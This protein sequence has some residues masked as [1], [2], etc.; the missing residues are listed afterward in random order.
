VLRFAGYELD[1]QRAELRSPNGEAIKL[2]PKS[3]DMLSLFATNSGR[4]LSK[5]ELIETV[6]PNVHVSED[7][8]F[9][10]I[11]DIRNALGDERRELIRLVSGRGYLFN[12][13]VTN[14]P[15]GTARP[16]VDLPTAVPEIA[17]AAPK[18]AAAS[19]QQQ[20]AFG[21]RGPGA[22]AIVA[23]LGALIGL[24]AA[25]PIIAPGL[26]SAPKPPA[27]AV[28]PMATADTDPQ[29]A[30]MA[31]GVT[32]RLTNGLA[33]IEG[34]R[35]VAPRATAS[36]APHSASAPP[37]D[38]LVSGEIQKG[39]ASW[40]VQARMISASTGEVRWTT[41]VTVR[42]DDGDPAILQSRLAAGIGHPLALRLNVLINAGARQSKGQ[43]PD[44]STKVVIEQA[45]AVIN[46]STR[47]RFSAARTMLEK[48]LA[49]DPDNVD[50][51]VALASHLMRGIQTVWS[52][53]ADIPA[54]ESRARAML[55]RALQARPSYIPVREAYC[56]FHAAT[57][58]LAEGLLACAR[59]LSFDPW[60]GT[61][62]FNL[63]IIQILQG[64]FEEALATFKQ[65]DAYDTPQVSRW[66]W[67]L[68]AGLACTLLER[69]NEALPWLQRSLAIT[70]GTGRT[71]MLLAGVLYKLGRDEEARAEMANGL[72]LRPGS[73]A[74]NISLPT[75]NASP[76]FIAAT[77]KLR[78]IE[79][80]AG[81]PEQ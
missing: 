32:E 12:V 50:L 25:A 28:V 29:I 34:I 62:L 22:L 42:M 66:T 51:E 30:G 4:V 47:E 36:L 14:R 75:R 77:D 19:G 59:A 53:P 35:V 57:N 76:I 11:R 80:E 9:Q 7:S 45:T 54:T 17:A 16:A 39:T 40:E 8:L 21:R 6:W 69:Y 71:Q 43:L 63:G 46:Q 37:A 2:R 20:N 1:P 74:T 52:N 3:F 31:A 44:G 79:V 67:L 26:L 55:E 61:A 56:R 72:A 41:S 64:R 27:I 23:G 73:N 68:G 58:G 24:A 65:A 78:K 81:L 18:A 5:Q 49:A 33:R 13:E 48:A 60:N 38:F 10:C 15:P 70:P